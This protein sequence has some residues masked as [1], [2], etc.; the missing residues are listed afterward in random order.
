LENGVPQGRRIKIRNANK[1]KVV[2]WVALRPNPRSAGGPGTIRPHPRRSA[3]R[4][5]SQREPSHVL[6]RLPCGVPALL[7]AVRKF[8]AV[9]AYRP[10]PCS[11]GGYRNPT[12]QLSLKL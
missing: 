3:R 8:L 6:M 7:N 11:S 5:G 10:Q 1:I 4:D 9:A 2:G 12:P